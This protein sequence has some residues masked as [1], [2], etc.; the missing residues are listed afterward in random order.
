M[1]YLTNLDILW[2][3]CRMLWNSIG[4][5]QE[6][7]AVIGGDHD[8]N[9]SK[10]STISS[11]KSFVISQIVFTNSVL[12]ITI[13]QSDHHRRS[14]GYQERILTLISYR[15]EIRLEFVDVQW[16][17]S[18]EFILFLDLLWPTNIIEWIQ[19]VVRD[20]IISKPPRLRK[21]MISIFPTLLLL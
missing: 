3:L 5:V 21:L 6:D 7:Q 1:L 2:S 9:F 20:G 11:E 12:S 15:Q 17:L 14:R 8:W 16:I 4:D 13:S 18:S 19:F 10:Y